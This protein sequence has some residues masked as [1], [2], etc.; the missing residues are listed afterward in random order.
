MYYLICLQALP[1]EVTTIPIL[2]IG[3]WGSKRSSLPRN[4]ADTVAELRFEPRS[5]DSKMCA[6]HQRLPFPDSLLICLM[7]FLLSPPSTPLRVHLFSSDFKLICA[8]CRRHWKYRTLEGK[9]D[10]LHSHSHMYNY[11]QSQA[12]L[13]NCSTQLCFHQIKYPMNAYWFQVHRNY[14]EYLKHHITC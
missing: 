14:V 5:A 8:N 1:K 7:F 6:L 13:I 3:N 4:T 2:Q 12:L 9:K 11:S 10:H